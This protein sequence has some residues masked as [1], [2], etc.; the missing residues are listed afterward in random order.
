MR[1]ISSIKRKYILYISL[2]CVISL[3]ILSCISYIFSYRI[4]LSTLKEK[5]SAYSLRYSQ[6]I[7]SW[8]TVQ[9]Q[10]LEW[11]SHDISINEE[12]YSNRSNVYKLLS[13][14]YRSSLGIVND[15]YMSY[16]DK[17]LISGSDWVPQSDYDCT[18]RNWYILASQSG[19]TVFTEPYVDA[20]ERSGLRMVITI[21]TPVYSEDRLSGVLAADITIDSLVKLVNSINPAKGGYAFLVD[22]NNAFITHPEK[23]FLPT[24]E[25][26]SYIDKVFNG[27]YTK[28]SEQIASRSYSI[29]QIKDFDG[30][31]KYFIL[32]EIKSSGWFLCISIPQT[33]ISN[34]LNILLIGF[35]VFTTLSALISMVIIYFLISGMIRPVISLTQAVKEF[36]DKK[37]HVRSTVYSQDEI[38]ELCNS[39]NKMADLIQDYSTTLENKVLERTKELNEKNLKIQESIE[40][41]NMIQIAILPSDSEMKAFLGDY[42]VIWQPRDTVGGDFYWT[43]NFDDGFLVMVGDCT[44]HGIPGALMTMAVNAIIDHITQD[45]CHNDPARILTEMDRLVNQLL[46]RDR[47]ND[48]VSDGLDIGIVFISEKKDI[49]F[50]GARISLFTADNAQIREIKASNHTIGHEATQ[51]EKKFDNISVK[52]SS[53]MALYLMTDGIKDQIGGDKKL[54]FGKTNV[55]KI[56][57]SVWD[58]PMS[59][60]KNLIYMKYK[61]YR[62]TEISR[63]DITMFGLRL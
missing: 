49:L 7:D 40:Y 48:T 13:E 4:V 23:D 52:H 8:L 5:L 1:K 30:I 58:K 33:E 27:G 31:D 60:Q 6:E 50:C 24:R 57:E 15:Y 43:K 56:L 17:T 55:I 47:S 41:A 22:G 25:K 51:R 63:D 61:E 29:T 62:N 16:T 39:F 45:I 46:H 9:S 11:I 35:T 42:F 44:G 20:D 26:H 14:K 10:K 3:F 59:E 12:Y 36:G 54:P 18:Q 37:M 2:I 19:K 38:G 21:S 34:N 32:S 53:S 28:L